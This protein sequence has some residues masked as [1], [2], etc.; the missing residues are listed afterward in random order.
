MQIGLRRWR[1]LR[2]GLGAAVPT[3][4]AGLVL[5]GFPA[6]IFM[7]MTSDPEDEVVTLV[8]LASAGVA[9]AIAVFWGV[10]NALRFN[11]NAPCA[12]C[13]LSLGACVCCPVCEGS[14]R[15]PVGSWLLPDVCL[16]CFGA[17]DVRPEKLPE[18]ALRP[19]K[20]HCD[21]CGKLHYGKHVW[22]VEVAKSH[23]GSYVRDLN[24]RV[25]EY[26]ARSLGEHRVF[27]CVDCG[28]A[29]K[30]EREAEQT[31]AHLLTRD[32]RERGRRLGSAVAFGAVEYWGA[33]DWRAAQRAKS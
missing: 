2:N 10:R 19:R 20:D 31:A 29:C 3:A 15:A 21:H 8:L 6:V 12:R 24:T 18:E 27:L 32:L 16:A 22:V 5:M 33:A 11:A 14:G 30:T 28:K 25:D 23:Q 4:I 26:R 17:G 1:M 13:G 9:G 7:V